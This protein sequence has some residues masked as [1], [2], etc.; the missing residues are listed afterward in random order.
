MKFCCRMETT[1][2][3]ADSIATDD[4]EKDECPA[5]VSRKTINEQG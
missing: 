5:Q 4:G 2:L 1:G 3:P